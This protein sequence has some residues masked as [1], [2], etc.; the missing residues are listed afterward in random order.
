MKT[1][2]GKATPLYEVWK[3]MRKRCNNPSHYAYKNYGGRGIKVCKRWDSYEL[4]AADIGPHPG[5]GWWIDR[6]N[7]SGSYAL[8]NVRWAT[9][10]TQ[11]RNRRNTKLSILIANKIRHEYNIGS[12]YAVLSAKFGVTPTIIGRVIRGE[13][14]L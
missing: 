1:M 11:M 6:I 2:N 4:F 13:T 5:K 12:T 9:P 10:T 7:N 3:A 8:G 14:W